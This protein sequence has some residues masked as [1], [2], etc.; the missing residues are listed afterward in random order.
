MCQLFSMK[1]E[2]DFI[3]ELR[4]K[5]NKNPPGPAVRF[6]IGDDC[7]VLPKDAETDLVI[8]T[9]LLIEEIDFRPDWTAP[10]LLG[11]KALAVSLSDVAAMGARP[12]WAML[13]IGVP[14]KI[15]QSDF[16][17]KFYDGWF[18]L[19]DRFGVELVGGDV[20][21]TPDRIVVDSIAAGELKSGRAVLRA[22]A[23]PGDLLF[24]TGALGGA[25]AGLK[26]LENGILLETAEHVWQKELLL[27]QLAPE[28]RVTEGE[29]IGRAQTVTSMIDL[30]DGLSSDLLHICRESNVGAE[31]FADRLPLDE[32]LKKMIGSPAERFD[33]ALN[34]GE[35]FELL[36]T[37]SPHRFSAAKQTLEAFDVHHIG[38]INGKPGS[39]ELIADGAARP[40]RAA[41][42]R[43]F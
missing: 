18:R 23:K 5:K 42:F 19:A 17:E 8:T 3:R 22:G 6:G 41:G 11:H 28:P 31:I 4:N 10:A 39:V 24:V 43:H 27:R 34:G 37:V 25:S 26:L 7:A 16:V 40:L 36:F 32:N 15:W 14:E 35:D 12:V 13:S 9:D 30:S 29:I 38:L 2:F 20:S 33:L 1:T 21:R